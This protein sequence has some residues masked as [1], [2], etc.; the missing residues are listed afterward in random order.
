MFEKSAFLPLVGTWISFPGFGLTR[1]KK[2]NIMDMLDPG[3]GIW[4]KFGRGEIKT[5]AAAVFLFSDAGSP[6]DN[7]AHKDEKNGNQNNG[8]RGERRAADG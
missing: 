2:R 5:R 4:G 8:I 6:A 1:E 3:I 7:S